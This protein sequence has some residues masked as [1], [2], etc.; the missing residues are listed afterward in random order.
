MIL[1]PGTQ[2]SRSSAWNVTVNATTN[3]KISHGTEIRCVRSHLIC[4]AE[5]VKLNWQFKLAHDPIEYQCVPPIYGSEEL[6]WCL[7]TGTCPDTD[8]I[9]VNPARKHVSSPT[10]SIHEPVARVQFTV[11]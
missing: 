11:R 9:A 10:T 5:N 8:S 2:V 4:S 1:E 7:Q 3:K 6:P